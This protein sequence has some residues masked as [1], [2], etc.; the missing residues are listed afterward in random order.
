MN[1]PNLSTSRNSNQGITPS[2]NRET[3]NL[4]VL[5]NPTENRNETTLLGN[6]REHD[7]SIKQETDRI[8]PDVDH[9]NSENN[10]ITNRERVL[11]NN[12]FASNNSIFLNSSNSPCFDIIVED[13]NEENSSEKDYD[14]QD[15]SDSNGEL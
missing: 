12:N 6:K 10:S 14:Q 13:F 9:V 1:N 8:S 3:N 11:T 7:H 4:N 15:D 5:N 2:E